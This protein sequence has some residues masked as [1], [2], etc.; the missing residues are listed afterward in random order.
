MAIETLEGDFVIRG[1]YQDILRAHFTEDSLIVT[2]GPKIMV[3]GLSEAK[4]L[5]DWIDR[6]LNEPR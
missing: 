3:A 4:E 2:M 6:R 1:T 5:R